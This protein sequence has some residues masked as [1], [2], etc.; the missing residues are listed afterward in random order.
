MTILILYFKGCPNLAPTLQVVRDVLRDL[1]HEV[2]ATVRE[3]EVKSAE[4]A[5]RLRFFG[6]PTLQVEGEDIDPTVRGR[7]D[8]SFSCRVYGRAGTPPREMIERAIRERMVA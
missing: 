6:S 3:V 2:D 4:D 8:Y 5:S 7:S 1:H